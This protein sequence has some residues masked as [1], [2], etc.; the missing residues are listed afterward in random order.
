VSV[1]DEELRVWAAGWLVR[2]PEGLFQL[3]DNMREIA[4]EFGVEPDSDELRETI[5]ELAVTILM[6][7]AHNMHAVL[8][9]FFTDEEIGA[10]LREEAARARD[11]ESKLISGDAVV[12][13]TTTRVLKT[14]GDYFP[15]RFSE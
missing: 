6:I 1:N 12:E 13:A 3:E 5:F 2:H 4:H 15:G 14:L 7:K 8:D 10:I 9:E 11:P